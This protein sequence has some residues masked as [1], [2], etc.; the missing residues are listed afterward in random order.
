[1]VVVIANNGMNPA[2]ASLGYGHQMTSWT[3]R[4]D[5]V[6]DAVSAWSRRLVLPDEPET[7]SSVARDDTVFP[8]LPCSQ[9]SWNGLTVGVE[10]LDATLRLLQQQVEAGGPILPTANYTVLRA[11][12]VG[13]AQ[14][15]VLLCS[16]SMEERT[17]VGLQLAH[18]EYR[19][20]YNFRRH[21]LS[22][23]GLVP[24]AQAAAAEHDHLRLLEERLRQVEAL[25]KER[26]ASNRVRD[27]ELV[28]RAAEL[29]HPRGKNAEL[30]RLA[31]EMEWQLGSGA[32]HGRLI[33]GLQRPGGHVVRDGD[34]AGLGVSY[35]DIAQQ[36][37]AVSLVLSAAW[38]MWDLRIA[39]DSA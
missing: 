12:L 6:T 5:Q 22:H 25:L 14:A 13:S 7:G 39:S 1:M 2:G 10:H 3:Y 27:T 11:A 23:A 15:V 26:G 32:A 37:G 30:M 19:Q 31:L 21:I 33:M 20:A 34:T 28:A 16:G 4:V 18:E 17:T 38:Q 35:D 8:R 36:V 24:Q 9:L 29:V